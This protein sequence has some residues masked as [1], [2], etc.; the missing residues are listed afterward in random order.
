ML[1]RKPC[2]YA[3]IDLPPPISAN[4]IWRNVVVGGK[5]R[6]LKSK[7]YLAWVSEAGAMLNAQKPGFVE[8]HYCLT[9]TVTNK[10]RID[11]DNTVKAVNDLLQSQGVVSN[12]RLC[13]EITIRRG[14]VP[15]MS[16]LIVSTKNKVE[17][18]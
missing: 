17:A 14:N 5:P 11:L 4:A 12:D 15:G 8:G 7:A 9:I 2:G 10:S 18:A 3:A 16:V 1:G 6:T 13:E